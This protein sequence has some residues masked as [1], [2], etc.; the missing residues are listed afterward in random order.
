M[1]KKVAQISISILTLCLF[2][3]PSHP[4]YILTY[5]IFH[6]V[7]SYVTVTPAAWSRTSCSELAIQIG[8]ICLSLVVN[9]II[10]LEDADKPHIHHCHLCYHPCAI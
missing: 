2:S 3:L 4:P 10:R 7:L 6:L 5:S 9:T 1:Y 8:P